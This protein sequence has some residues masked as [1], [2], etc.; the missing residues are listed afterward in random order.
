MPNPVAWYDLNEKAGVSIRDRA[1]TNDGTWVGTDLV[2]DGDM[3]ND[4]SWVKGTGWVI[5]ATNIATKTA[6]VASNLSQDVS[7]EASKTYIITGDLVV[8]AGNVRIALGGNSFGSFLSSTQTISETITSSSV[9]DNSNVSFQ[10]NGS[11]AGTLDNVSVREHVVSVPSP[12][13][14]GL[15]FDGVDDA[16]TI[17]ADPVIDANG[18]TALTI[19]AWI[20]PASDGET[21]LGRVVDKTNSAGGPTTGYSVWV[22]DEGSGLLGINWRMLIVGDDMTAET[23]PV[24]PINTWS[25]IAVTYDKDDGVRKGKIYLNGV[26][27]TNSVTDNAGADAAISDDSADPL[28]IGNY[29]DSDRTFDGSISDVRIYDVALS[30]T[31]IRQIFRSD[32]AQR[33]LRQRYTIGANY[34]SLLP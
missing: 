10:S 22:S 11:F 7:I 8:T 14:S 6:G 32:E 29:Q 13:G 1:G 18:K 24:V 25:H 21:N 33:F 4:A 23:S 12:A 15:L 19:T 34:R 3:S 17:P 28:T 30:Q 5:G 27:Q 16:I 20:N 31:A 9:P 26:L 2:T